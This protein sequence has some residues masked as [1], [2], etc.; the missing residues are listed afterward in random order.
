M[1]IAA[2]G[3][4]EPLSQVLLNDFPEFETVSRL[5]GGSFQLSVSEN[6]KIRESG[7]FA[8][9]AFFKIF[10]FPLV[11]GS[12]ETVLDDPYSVVI[13]ESLADKLFGSDE[14]LGKVIR[15]D[16]SYDIKVTGVMKDIPDNSH[17]TFN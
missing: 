2:I 16:E 6:E 13:T 1:K 4:P 8:D 9:S 15:V 3:C 7:F 10:S 17:I 14:P 12:A 5:V 11:R